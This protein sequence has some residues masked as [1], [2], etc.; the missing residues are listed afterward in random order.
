MHSR[1]VAGR[2]LTFAFSARLHRGN[3]LLGDDATGSQWS[4]LGLRAVKGELQETPLTILPTVQTTWRHW[5]ELYPDTDVIE[6]ADE[7]EL[8]YSYLP[9]ASSVEIEQIT[10]V[11]GVQSPAIK[12][13]SMPLQHLK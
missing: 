13:Y 8:P 3:L 11:L 2:Q 9:E 4:Q 12:A 1:R 7:N 10:F 5:R 6:P